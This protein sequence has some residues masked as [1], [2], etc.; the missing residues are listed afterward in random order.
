M[1]RPTHYAGLIFGGR[2]TRHVMEWNDEDIQAYVLG[3]LLPADHKPSIPYQMIT[4]RGYG[5]SVTK[6]VEGDWK[7]KYGK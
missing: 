4:W 6:W 3:K 5:M 2:A 1:Y 7:N